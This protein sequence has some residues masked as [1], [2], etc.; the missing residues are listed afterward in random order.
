MFVTVR[1]VGVGGQNCE[2]S[3]QFTGRVYHPGKM[4][5]K[6]TVVDTFR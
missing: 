5:L 6:A 4:F 1:G 2:R 3:E